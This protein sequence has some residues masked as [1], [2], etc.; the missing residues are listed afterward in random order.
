MKLYYA[1][2][3]CSL[4]VH[5]VFLE[6]KL[7]FTLT[8]VDLKTHQTEAGTD[9]YTIN[10]KGAVPLLEL[11]NGEHLSE[12]PVIAQYIADQ[13]DNTDIMPKVGTMARYRVMEWQSYIGAELHKNFGPLFGRPMALEAPIKEAFAGALKKK[14]RWVEQ[15]L[16]NKNFL[17]GDTFTAADAYL[18]VICRWTKAVAI[19]LAADFPTLHRYAER[20]AQRPTVQAALKAEGLL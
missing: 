6:C 4:A 14:L 10:S 12:G 15:Q 16:G 8:K 19:D 13:A 3:V 7:P 1:P 2:G 5:I 20:I 17:T 11:D 9:Y 18:Y